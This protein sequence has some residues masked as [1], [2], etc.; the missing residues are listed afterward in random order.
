MCLKQ[1]GLLK[2]I[3]S[4]LVFVSRLCKL[5]CLTKSYMYVNGVNISYHLIS[6]SPKNIVE[7][8]FPGELAALPR[9]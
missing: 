9:P 6:V 4:K 5:L 3:G 1:S 7:M 8:A 2:G